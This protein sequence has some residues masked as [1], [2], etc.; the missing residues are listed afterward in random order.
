MPII[1]GSIVPVSDTTPRVCAITSFQG[2]IRATGGGG[3]IWDVAVNAG[4]SAG[5]LAA[6]LIKHEQLPVALDNHA[7]STE[8]PAS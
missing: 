5:S 2:R 7:C 6:T 3:D 1:G 4:A 8:F